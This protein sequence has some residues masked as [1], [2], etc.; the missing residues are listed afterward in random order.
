MQASLNTYP[1]RQWGEPIHRVESGT[2]SVRRWN[3][4]ELAL[5][6]TTVV[7]V[8]L[9]T[10]MAIVAWRLAR[11][12]RIRSEARVA[13][14]AAELRDV[15]GLRDQAAAGIGG[16]PARLRQVSPRPADFDLDLHSHRISTPAAEMFQPRAS[17][18]SRSRL[19]TV[20]AV[21]SFAVAVSLALVVA[22]SRG[23]PS[24]VDRAASPATLPARAATATPLELLAL[25]HHRDVDRI[26]IRGVVRNPSGGENVEALTAVAYL[27]D[28][29]GGF[30]G[31]GGSPLDLPILRPGRESAFVVSVGPASTVSRYRVSFRIGNRVV[32][33]VDRRSRNAIS[34]TAR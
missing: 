34:R 30:V 16:R 27:F 11:A 17:D 18:Q 1:E 26:T 28:R 10:A 31:H 7:S 9:A 8:G 23:G 20:L 29:E 4:M 21:G 25:S 5:I 12:E 6:V 24:L 32:P 19:A 22:T 3:S 13:A 14:P 33:H 2:S 15:E